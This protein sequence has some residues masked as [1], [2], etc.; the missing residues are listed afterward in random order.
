MEVVTLI[1]KKK[2]ANFSSPH[3]F[4]FIDGTL[5]PACSKEIGEKYKVTFHEEVDKDGDVSL[6]FSLS[7][8]VLER[9][10]EFVALKEEGKVDVVFVPLPMM[11][12]MRDIF[13]KE[14]IKN[15]PFRCIRI[16][17]RNSKLLSIE[18]QCL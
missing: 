5:L 17:D 4:A 7:D 9:M 16:E 14:D 11:T 13:K 10:D 2:V 3:P 8:D 15:M 6:T 1:N 18:K 12:A